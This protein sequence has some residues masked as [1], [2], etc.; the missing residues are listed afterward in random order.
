MT[1]AQVAR[2]N[3]DWFESWSE[4]THLEIQKNNPA[5]QEWL[6]NLDKSSSLPSA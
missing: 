3:I 5:D 6:D 2:S 1:F 4:E